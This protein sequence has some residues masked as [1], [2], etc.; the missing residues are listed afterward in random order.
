MAKFLVVAA[1]VVLVVWSWRLA[2]RARKKDLRGMGPAAR[3]YH[4]RFVPM[5]PLL[6]LLVA[7]TGFAAVQGAGAFAGAM[8]IVLGV[9]VLTFGAE[10]WA[11]RRRPG[12]VSP[13]RSRR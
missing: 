5:L 10:W 12:P 4:R 7:V 3:V 11:E 9:V 1:A 2:R 6:A 8:G 13:G